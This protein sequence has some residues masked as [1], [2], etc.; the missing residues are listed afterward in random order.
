MFNVSRIG[1]SKHN[2]DEASYHTGMTSTN[3]DNHYDIA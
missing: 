3:T 2:T 1:G